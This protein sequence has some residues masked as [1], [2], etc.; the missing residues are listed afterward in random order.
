MLRVSVSGA[1]QTS[2]RA[3]CAAGGLQLADGHVFGHRAGATSWLPHPTLAASPLSPFLYRSS[4]I[5]V[6]AARCP[7]CPELSCQRSFAGASLIPPHLPCRDQG[8]RSCTRVPPAS[9]WLTPRITHSLFLSPLVPSCLFCAGCTQSSPVRSFII[10]L[11]PHWA[12]SV[13]PC[14][15]LLDRG[16]RRPHCCFAGLPCTPLLPAHPSASAAADPGTLVALRVC[17]LAQSESPRAAP[18]S[19]SLVSLSL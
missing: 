9:F 16:V 5:A 14:P 6:F 10:T 13:H 12:S 1:N 19:C 2:G 7:S 4:V 3:P 8:S 15:A 11:S 17:P 18:S